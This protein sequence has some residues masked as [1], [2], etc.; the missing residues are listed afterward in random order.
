MESIPTVGAPRPEWHEQD[1]RD[2]GGTA[3]KGEAAQASRRVRREQ[4]GQPLDR[5][6]EEEGDDQRLVLVEEVELDQLAGEE[7]QDQDRRG[8]QQEARA[9]ERQEGQ[10]PEELRQVAPLLQREDA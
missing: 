10:R 5:R 4:V 1:R 2:D 3:E 8:D 6:Q 7:I 9:Q